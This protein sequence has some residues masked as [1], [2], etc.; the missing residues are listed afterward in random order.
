[1]LVFSCAVAG[2]ARP[3]SPLPTPEFADT[4][5]TACHSLDQ[6]MPSVCGL[7]LELAFWGTSS[8]N[9][10]IVFGRDDDGDANLSF[11]ESDVRVGWDCG[12]YFIE[13]IPTGE[14]FEE[15]SAETNGAD[16]ILRWDC[17]LRHRVMRGLAVSNE[18]GPAF[19]TVTAA[20]PS[21]LYDAN[22]D[23]LRLTARGPEAT[24]ERFD[25]EVSSKGVVIFYAF[26]D[27]ALKRRAGRKE[28]S[29]L[30]R[31]HPLATRP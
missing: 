16:R 2:F 23:T 15:L 9:V 14:R 31:S 17:A 7:N 26:A 24:G 18:V 3:L 8:N 12:R 25:V 22:W 20:P 10:E 21:W 6:A 19:A 13:R 1:M 30:A 29:H 5:V 11:G 4:E 27:F 28:M